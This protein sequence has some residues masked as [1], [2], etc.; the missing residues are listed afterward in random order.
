MSTQTPSTEDVAWQY[1]VKRVAD[2]ATDAEARSEFHIWLAV[3]N[4][5]VAAR[6][7]RVSVE[8]DAFEVQDM[9]GD[10][11]SVV[12]T[13]DLLMRADDLEAGE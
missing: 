2:G 8:T 1:R 11:F 9:F 13:E 3:H 12:A 7:L 4:R 10:K 5:K 6:A